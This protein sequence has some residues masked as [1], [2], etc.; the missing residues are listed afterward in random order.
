MSIK[1]PKQYGMMQGIAHGSSNM[2]KG[3]GPS[4][5]VAMEFIN[6]T[7]KKKRSQFAQS[8]ANKR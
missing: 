8:L 1:S 2:S 3:A 4:K 5:A 6:K 7:P